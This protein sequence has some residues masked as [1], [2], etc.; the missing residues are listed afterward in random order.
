[1]R[2]G[3]IDIGSNSVRLL[4]ADREGNA[5]HRQYSGK[6]TTRLIEGMRDECLT[7][8]AIA[9]TRDAI[10]A[11][12]TRAL[13]MRCERIFAFGTAALRRA[14]NASALL[15]SIAACRLSIDI[16]SGEQEALLAYLGVGREGGVLDIGGGSTEIILG[17]GNAI[18]KSISLPLGAVVCRERAQSGTPLP[19]LMAEAREAARAFHDRPGTPFSG[20][21]GTITTAAAMTLKAAVYDSAAISKTVL[22][23]EKVEELQSLIART[24]I[25][26]RQRIPGLEPRRADIIEYGLALLAGLMDGLSIDILRVSDD[27]NMIGYLRWRDA[28]CSKP[29]RD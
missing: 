5:I 21:G 24:P 2:Y 23:R 12:H 3:V 4:V 17:Q 10:I 16:L 6:E 15:E 14:I 1:M 25:S 18:E 28:D 19:A 11:L 20:I 26:E 29:G 9:R 13:E 22:A 7:P 27:D 8:E